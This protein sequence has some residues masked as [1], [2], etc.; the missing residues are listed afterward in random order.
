MWDRK[1]AVSVPTQF[2]ESCSWN[3]AVSQHPGDKKRKESKEFGLL[4]SCW[5]SVFVWS[6]SRKCHGWDSTMYEHCQHCT[7]THM[8]FS[9]E[10]KP[11]IFSELCNPRCSIA[12]SVLF[13]KGVA[14]AIKVCWLNCCCCFK[15]VRGYMWVLLVGCVTSNSLVIS[16]TTCCY[17]LEFSFLHCFY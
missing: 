2:S 14:K 11:Y 16:K 13:R 17:S 10:R 9:V 7:L 4:S 15:W 1:S 8:Q 6:E 12:S 5:N 3:P